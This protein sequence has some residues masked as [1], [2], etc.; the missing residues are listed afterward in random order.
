MVQAQRKVTIH[1]L[2]R[3][4]TGSDSL[5]K[6]TYYLWLD[7]YSSQEEYENTKERYIKRGFRVVTFKVGPNK[8]DIEEGIKALIRNHIGDFYR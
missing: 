1:I 8:P 7:D 6:P 5:K 2:I 4:Q 3:I